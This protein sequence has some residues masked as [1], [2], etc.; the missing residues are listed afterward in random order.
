MASKRGVAITAAIL[1]IVTAA[2]FIVWALPHDDARQAAVSDFGAHLEG[3]QGIHGVLSEE[4]DDSFARL[5]RDE[6]TAEQYVESAEAA[7]S[8]VNS[9]IVQLIQ[10]GAPEQW[11]ES[12]LTYADA[13]RVQNSIIRETVV[14]AGGIGDSDAL[15]EAESRIGSLRAE[16]DSLVRASAD[17]AP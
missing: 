3:V 13:L 16:M 7:S 14:A 10:S 12:Y 8:Q 5:Q 9:Q 11:H 1:G 6:I 15:A 17:A 4:I 2:S